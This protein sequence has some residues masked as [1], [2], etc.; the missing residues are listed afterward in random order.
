MRTP[1]C[2]ISWQIWDDVVATFG[3]AVAIAAPERRNALAEAAAA[4]LADI[5]GAAHALA[6]EQRAQSELEAKKVAR[7]VQLRYGRDATLDASGPPAA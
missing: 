4:A 5:A 7:Y 3:N 6:S 1:E 2:A